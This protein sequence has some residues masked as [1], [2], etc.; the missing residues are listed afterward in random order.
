MFKKKLINLFLIIW[1]FKGSNCF[2]PS[3][4][5]NSIVENIDKSNNGLDFGQVSESYSHEEILRRGLIR[6]VARFFHDQPNGSEKVNLT[7]M[8]RYFK[9]ISQLYRDYY[10]SSLISL[11]GD[12]RLSVLLETVLQPQVAAVDLNQETKH[13][14]LAHFDGE[15][16]EASNR[17]VIK[18]MKKID[19]ALSKSDYSTARQLSGQVL[20]TIQDF[21]SHSNWV[22]MSS[23]KINSA[24]G[25][26]EFSKRI[27]STKFS[28]SNQCKSNCEL[29]TIKCSL[30]LNVISII[31]KR[32]NSNIRLNCP[33][34]YYKCSGNI[35]TLNKMLSG[36]SRNSRLRNGTRVNNPG[37][38][39]K[40]NHGGI[41]DPDS[42]VKDA[43]GGINKDAG[44][45]LIS[46][47]ANLHVKAVDL[48]ILHTEHFFNSIRQK[49][50]DIKF[51]EFLNIYL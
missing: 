42:F 17:R 29:V 36:Y 22:E 14:P 8:E 43:L 47:H 18:F 21:Y 50:G 49:F 33:L 28:D 16:L 7:D 25:T 24:I 35:V 51:A 27:P 11:I 6:S 12:I 41:V 44:I 19:K 45:Y 1:F 13:L 26:T 46:P 15:R 37:G 9:D 4:I 40:C 10:C 32:L 38:M 30:S 31:M 3:Q 20:H 23:N 5:I 48:A 39:N 34:K 2:I